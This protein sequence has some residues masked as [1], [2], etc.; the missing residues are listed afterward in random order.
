MDLHDMIFP[1]VPAPLITGPPVTIDEV[2]AFTRDLYSRWALPPSLIG[3]FADAPPD[4]VEWMV[5]LYMELMAPYDD[6]FHFT[7]SQREYDML[8][9]GS[10]L[11]YGCLLQL[12]T[13]PRWPHYIP[14]IV[15]YILL[16]WLVDHYLDD[17]RIPQSTRLHRATVLRARMEDPSPHPDDDPS[18]AFFT[19]VYTSFIHDCPEGIPFLLE[20]FDIEIESVRTQRD[21][22]RSLDYQL[23]LLYRK[24]GYTMAVLGVFGHMGPL[25]D[26]TT[27]L[28]NHQQQVGILV[29][30]LDDFLDYY[31]DRENG[32]HNVITYCVD[33][34]Q[35]PT[36]LY[37]ILHI[38]NGLD[39]INNLFRIVALHAFAYL[40]T[41]SPLCRS[42]GELISFLTPYNPF[43]GS[44]RLAHELT[45]RLHHYLRHR[46]SRLNLAPIKKR[47][48]VWN[49]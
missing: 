36:L 48:I 3:L 33:H 12:I 22:T 40:V 17:E 37:H 9:S 7:D 31:E 5:E 1:G 34:H 8:F 13:Y 26:E 14:T 11:F 42:Y 27:R 21:P 15:N 10:S 4:G 43:P 2:T 19:A 6:F 39:G 30:F 46:K 41:T 18:L 20:L 45:P 44:G 35:L 49:D 25:T 23:R 24:G 47:L 38:M 29:Q 32:Y 28:I 16:Y